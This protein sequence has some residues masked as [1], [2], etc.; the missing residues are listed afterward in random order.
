MTDTTREHIT[1]NFPLQN[2]SRHILF[3]L[4]I[5][6]IRWTKDQMKGGKQK[7]KRK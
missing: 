6:K 4:H 7:R 1:R 5:E 3:L 2:V